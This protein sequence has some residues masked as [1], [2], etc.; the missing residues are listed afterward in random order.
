MLWSQESA[1]RGDGIGWRGHRTGNFRRPG[2]SSVLVTQLFLQL[3]GKHRARPKPAEAFR[4]LHLQLPDEGQAVT[5]QSLQFPDRPAKTHRG[6]TAGWSL[7][8]AFEPGGRG[9][10]G[11]LR[12]LCTTGTDRGGL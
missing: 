4:F 11:R 5:R 10:R 9:P 8:A 3:K 6:G 1:P 7:S 12:A 2:P